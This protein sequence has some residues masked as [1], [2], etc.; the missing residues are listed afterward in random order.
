MD[1]FRYNPIPSDAS[2]QD[3]EQKVVEPFMS[4]P[5][6]IPAPLEIT[7]GHLGD[8]LTVLSVHG[9][10]DLMTSPYLTESIDT[11]LTEAEPSALIIDLTDVPFLA[12]V[13]MSILIET[14]SRMGTTAQ[15]AVVADAPNTGRPLTLMGL[16]DTFAIYTDRSAAITALR[17]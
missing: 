2:V 10:L 14:C 16:N 17:P 8:G 12:S 4:T 6:A 7:V 11:V 9:E 3:R 15:F 13:G 5:D 1:I